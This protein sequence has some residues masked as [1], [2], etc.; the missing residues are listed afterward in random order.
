MHENDS[1]CISFL[2]GGTLQPIQEYIVKF[3]EL[4]FHG[5]NL[6]RVLVRLCVGGVA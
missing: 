2:D 4:F 1:F 6:M 5:F 3:K